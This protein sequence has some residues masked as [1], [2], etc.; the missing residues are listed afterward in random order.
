MALRQRIDIEVFHAASGITYDPWVVAGER[1]DGTWEAVLEFV[2]RQGG[3]SHLT[4]VETTQPAAKDVLYWA[5]GLSNSYFDGA[6]DRALRGAAGRKR[7]PAALR[8]ST[9]LDPDDRLAQLRMIER[10]I[11]ETFRFNGATALPADHF[12]RTGP[13]S[14]ADFVRAFEDLEK[15][16]RYLVRQTEGG[17]DRLNLTVEGAEALGLAVNTVER[18]VAEPA[19]P[20]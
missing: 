5:G 12:F 18:A 2:P 8:P 3:V 7:S 19:Q 4:D 16:W 15:H 1:P 14:N 13:Y 6:F 9:P 11:M 20:R 10:L 17:S